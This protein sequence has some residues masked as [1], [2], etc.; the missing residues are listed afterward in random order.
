MAE[1]QFRVRGTVADA[2]LTYRQRLHRL[3]GLAEEAVDGPAVGEAC[4]EALEK[5]VICDL[6]EGHAPYRPRYVLPDYGVLLRQGSAFLELEPARD[7]DE[8][9]AFLLIA[10]TAVPSITTYPVYLGDLDK[11]LA[12]YVDGVGDEE[13]YKRLRLFWISLD[14]MLPDAFVHTNIGPEDT[15]VGRTILRLERELKQVVPNLT[16]KVDPASTPDDLV[17][18][19]VRTVFE[20]AKPHFANHPMMV[21][22][23]GADYAVVSCYNSLKVGGG[24]HTLVRLNLAEVARQCGGTT[25]TFLT[26]TLPH[27]VELTAQL[28]EARVRYLVEVAGFYEHDWLV[29]EGLIS[30]DRFSAMFGIYGLAEA[31]EGLLDHKAYGRDAEANELSY[32]ITETVAA[33]VAARPLPYC[34]GN[35]GRA[36][37]HAQSGIDSDVGVTAGTRIPVGREPA[38][39]EHLSAVAPHHRLFAAGVSDV[40]AF[41]DTVR[42]NPRAVVDIIRGVFSNG[43]RDFTF[44]L[45]SNDFIRITGYLVRKSDLAKNARHESTVLG[46]GSIRNSH[47]DRR[48]V[49]RVISHESD[50]RAGR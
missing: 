25:E 31:V 35:G 4:R 26:E 21:G 1:L 13:L 6:A 28:I 12:P 17:L 7:L 38:L 10:Y 2:G 50:P 16:L 22:D 37:L 34:E 32:R 46:A 8:A 44:N 49:K 19:G 48:S 29:D 40:L 20:C 23:L 45:D 3:A 43:M 39:F 5:G 14:R 30:L 27:Y 41:D 42:R 18:D 24:S 15:R 11:L 47:V 36:F 9:L 33:L